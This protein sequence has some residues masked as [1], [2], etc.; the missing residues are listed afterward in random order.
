MKQSIINI[1]IVL[2]VIF[3]VWKVALAIGIQ[4]E[5]IHAFE[6]CIQEQY[7]MSST[8]YYNLTGQA[9]ICTY[10]ESEK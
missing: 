1:L 2:S 9:P 8:E 6:D 10:D 5:D 3:L 7:G 4:P